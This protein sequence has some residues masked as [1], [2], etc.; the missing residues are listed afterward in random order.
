MEQLVFAL[1][2]ILLSILGCVIYFSG[3]NLLLDAIF[4]TKGKAPDVAAANLRKISLIRPWLFLGPALLALIV[5][6]VYPIIDSVRISLFDQTGTHFV[7]L[8]NYVWLLGDGEFLKSFKNNMLWLI[9]VPAMS[10]FM[11]LII[12]AMTDRV[13]WGNIAK[14][15]I[16]MPMAISF[17]GASIIWKFIYDYRGDGAEQI[18]L[19][20]AVVELFGGSPEAW[21]TLPFWN[22]IFLMVILIWIQTGF[23][24]VILSAALRGISEETIE[25]AV[26]DGANGVQIFFKIMVPQIWSTIAVVW[27]TI[28]ILVLKVFD[29]VLAMTNGQWDTQVLANLMFDWMFRGG[30]DFGK[31]AAIAFIIMLLVVPIMVWNI[32]Q[33][34]SESGAR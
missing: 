22:N 19:L 6:L 33:I 1:L 11:G 13:W 12:A 7:G 24:M 14:S 30:G 34:D 31:G 8:D 28:T 4:S 16:F 10:T 15:L 23:A 25:A 29:I 5:Y 2:T 26:I 18:G 9:I 27:T 3:S 20:N 17:I 21:I 32:R